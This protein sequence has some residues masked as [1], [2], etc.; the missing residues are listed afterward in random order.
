MLAVKVVTHMATLTELVLCT[1]GLG[2]I[3]NFAYDYI[4]KQDYHNHHDYCSPFY[5][6]LTTNVPNCSQMCGKIGK[7]VM[8]GDN[9][10]NIG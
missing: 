7:L 5:S 3:D 6:K 1:L 8:V 10:P 4:V 2:E 9:Y